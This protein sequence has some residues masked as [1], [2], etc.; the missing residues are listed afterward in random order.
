MDLN[1]IPWDLIGKAAAGFA[2][3]LTFLWL[4]SRREKHR[5]TA[6][7][8]ADLMS[9]WG[10]RWFAEGYR[11]YAVGD[12]SGIV[13]KI[14]EVT[15]AVRSDK[16]LLSKLDDVFWKV[17]EHYKDDPAKVAEIKKRLEV[18]A[19]NPQQQGR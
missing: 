8:F 18:A 5:K 2:L 16:V 4:Y 17:L 11:Q 7:E 1:A 6:L 3:A 10:L 15:K 9:E 13:Y 14:A 19:A 12:Y